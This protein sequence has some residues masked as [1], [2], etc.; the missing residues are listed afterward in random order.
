MESKN[1]LFLLQ[2]ASRKAAKNRFFLAEN[3]SDFCSYRRMGEDELAKFLGCS[4]SVLPKLSLC[5]RPD[6]ESSRFRSD[7]EQIA[8][9][10]GIK[11]IQLAQLIREV[12]AIKALEKIK[13]V[14]QEASEGFLAVAR[15][16]EDTKPDEKEVPLSSEDKEDAK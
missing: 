5:R 13:P 2:L 15:D 3:L 11:S 14:K 1:D 8:S 7:I 4:S 9:V 10:F 16:T 6:P 12:E